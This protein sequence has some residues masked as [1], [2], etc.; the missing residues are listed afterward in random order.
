ML[1]FVDNALLWIV[2]N[3]IHNGVQIV[4]NE[5]RKNGSWSNLTI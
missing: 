1:Y 5:L 3:G 2:D 4:N